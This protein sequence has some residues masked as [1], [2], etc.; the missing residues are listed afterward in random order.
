MKKRILIGVTLLGASLLLGGCVAY[1]A[2]PGAYGGDPYY[3]GGY[4]SGYYAPAP[5][6]VAPSVGIG[7]SYS[8]GWGGRGWGG[9]GWHG[10]H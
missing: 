1:P 7:L 9:G 8:R 3:G 4:Y 5:V 10:G 6:Y 2:Y